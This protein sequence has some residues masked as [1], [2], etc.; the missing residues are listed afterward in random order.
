MKLKSISKYISKILR[1]EPEIIGITLDE[2]GWANVDELIKGIQETHPDFNKDLLEIIVAED[3]KQRYSFNGNHTLIRANQ[4]HSILVDVEL[5]KVIPPSVLYHGTGE[6]FVSSIQ[7]QGLIPKSRLYV[8]LSKDIETALSVGKR[9]GKPVVF[10]IDTQRMV[11]DHIDFYLSANQVWLTRHVPVQYLQLL[12]EH[13][14]E[15]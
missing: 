15:K 13:N 9:H 6:K 8:H 11:E 2:H 1:H 7:Q 3:N 10:Q 14:D 4:G 12:D 5:E